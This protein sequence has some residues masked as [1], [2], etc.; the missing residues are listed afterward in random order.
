MNCILEGRSHTY[1][2]KK[3]EAMINSIT[4]RE[5]YPD[6]EALK[7]VR[8]TRHKIISADRRIPFWVHKKLVQAVQHLGAEER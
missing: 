1:M 7:R 2:T 3:I 4:D 5:E 6:V 8:I